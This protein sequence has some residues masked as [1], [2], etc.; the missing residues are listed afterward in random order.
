TPRDYLAVSAEAEF[1]RFE[2]SPS[3]LSVAEGGAPTDVET[4]A[5]PLVV[6]YFSPSGFFAAVG[7]TFVR[8]DVELAPTS[9]FA[10]DSDEFFLVDASIGYRLPKR[11]GLISLE[12]KNLFDDDFLYQDP[13]IQSARAAQ[14][15]RFVPDRTV[16]LRATFAF[17]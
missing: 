4:I 7:G 3:D 15:P 17:H 16:F 11:R 1:E 14:Y 5:V 2:R 8:Q 9:A 12:A 10:R 13:S 6:R